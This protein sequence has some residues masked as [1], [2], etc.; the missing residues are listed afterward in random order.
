MSGV[1][2][3]YTI[4]LLLLCIATAAISIA[5]YASTRR[6]IF[7]YTCGLFVVYAIEMCT[8]FFY[9]YRGQN[10]AF[11]L[12][13]FYEID[14]VFARTLSSACILQF[15]WLILLD[16][17]QEERASFKYLPIVYYVIACIF[18]VVAL[19]YGPVKQFIYYTLRQVFAVGCIIYV[20]YVYKHTESHELKFRIDHSKKMSS[21]VIP[22]MS[23]KAI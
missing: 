17:V 19:P 10:V 4:D 8:I 5:A 13:T 15:M 16:I 11:S 12:D 1:F 20:W 21:R 22:I 2:F 7:S 14:S 18:V 6:K 9:E 3:F 23:A